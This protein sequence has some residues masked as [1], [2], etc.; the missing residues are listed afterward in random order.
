LDGDVTFTEKDD[1]YF[2]KIESKCEI[3]LTAAQRRWYVAKKDTLNDKM[4][5]EYPSTPKE[6]FEVAIEGAYFSDDM[7]D[8]RKQQRITIIPIEKSIDVDTFWDLGRNDKNSIWFMQQ[9][10][11]EYRF[12][13]YHENSGESLAY[14]ARVLKDKKEEHGYI[15]GKHYLPHDVRVTE[16]SS[17]DNRSRKQILEDSGVKPIITIDRINDV[18]EGIE[19]VRN[20]LPY[21]SFDKVRCAQGIK[22]LDNYRHKWDDKN[23]IFLSHPLH[24]WASNGADAFRQFAQSDLSVKMPFKEIKYDTL[25]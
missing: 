21:C 11:K 6:A 15:Y 16:L 10:G 12:I 7:A 20:I 2:H 22:C 3:T 5:R 18:N 24:D 14:Y 25:Y 8:A 13:D 19:L 1:K 4:K 23:S 17:I 9:V